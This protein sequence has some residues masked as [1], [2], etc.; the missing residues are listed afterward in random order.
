M[1][2]IPIGT[3]IRM[4]AEEGPDLPS[5][6]HEGRTV[7]RRELDLHTNRLARVYSELGVAEGHMVTIAL[8]N[9][10]E[11]YEACVAAWKLGAVPQPVSARLPKAERDAI[12]DLANPSLVVGV[13]EADQPRRATVPAGYEPDP[14]LDDS[15]LPERVAPSWKAPTSGGST[16]RPKIIVSGTE[17][18]FDSAPR[19]FSRM[20][21]G[22]CEV[23]PGPL[24]HNGPFTYSMQG[25]FMGK[26]LAV[27]SRF[28]PSLTLELIERHRCDWI[29]LVPTM[30]HR[31]WRLPEEEKQS[32]DLSSLQVVLHLAAPC[33]AWLKRAWIEWLGPD[34]IHE[35]YAGTEAQGVTWITGQEWLEHPGSVGKPILGSA[36]K[37]LDAEGNELPPGEV[38]EIYMRRP[39]DTPPTYHYV[40]AEPKVLD[41]WESLGDMGW[42]DE[43]GFLF[44]AD[45]RTDLILVGGSNVYPAEVEAALELHPAVRSCA[46]IG[47]PDEDMG[48]RVHAIVQ[49][50]AEVSDDELR[51]FLAERLVRYKVPR[52]FERVDEPLRDDAGKVR[53]SALRD[54]R[55]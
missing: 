12:V 21:P 50:D 51:E 34:V 5:I 17:G 9:G 40:G 46:V 55:L 3:V 52:S 14:A 22:G 24:Y 27:L 47:L 2:Q 26:H 25:L 44:M 18:V 42:M 38:G 13:E 33:P 32:R 1:A 48:H 39:P 4:R 54:A 43:D 7:T 31:I 23:V 45:R 20:E 36:M 53:R 15:P 41:G 19:T 35:L 6:T 11:F 28:D 10:I 8:P 49:A 37:I 30:M 29:L 16:G